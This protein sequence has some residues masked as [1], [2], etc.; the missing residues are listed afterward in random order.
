[1][2]VHYRLFRLISYYSWHSIRNHRTRRS[3]NI[4]YNFHMFYITPLHKGMQDLA[5]Q[6]KTCQCESKFDIFEKWMHAIY[7]RHVVALTMM[8]V[9]VG[10]RIKWMF[11]LR[12]CPSFYT[13]TRGELLLED[14]R[15]ILL[16]NELF[17]YFSSAQKPF[18]KPLS[19]AV[20]Y[21]PCSTRFFL[22]LT[23]DKDMAW[24]PLNRTKINFSILLAMFG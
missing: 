20:N 12:I 6:D 7:S 16:I 8:N 18:S 19:E 15:Y 3:N 1:M 10:K 5:A 23:I 17:N 9:S 13:F 24:S 22:H 14:V 2:H 21:V 11:L 4:S